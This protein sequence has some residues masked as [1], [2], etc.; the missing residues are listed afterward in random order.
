[1]TRRFARV[2]PFSRS[3]SNENVVAIDRRV[4]F[5]FSLRSQRSRLGRF[6]FLEP[7]EK[8]R[9]ISFTSN[10]SGVATGA[11]RLAG[12]RDAARS[13]G[14]NSNERFVVLS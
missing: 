7:K 2:L 9:Q 5:D 12:G 4:D 6:R 13:D 8:L 10:S 14:R 1:M 11:S 3:A